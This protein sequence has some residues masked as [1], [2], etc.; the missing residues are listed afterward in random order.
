MGGRDSSMTAEKKFLNPPSLQIIETLSAFAEESATDTADHD[1]GTAIIQEA[2]AQLHEADIADLIESLSKHHRQIVWS[3]L[4]KA[5]LG[6]VLLEVGN[7]LC[8]DL[9]ELTPTDT[10]VSLLKN[11]DTSDA[12]GL[13]RELPKSDAAKFIRLANLINNQE[14]RAS[15]SFKEDTVG[16]LMDFQPVIANELDTVGDILVSLRQMKSLPSHCDKLF[17]VDDWERLAG[18]LPLNRL[19]LNEPE[20]RVKDIMKA[21]NLHTFTAD[22]DLN[23]ASGAFERYNLISA[24]VIDE[25]HKIIGRITI[26]EIF[27]YFHEAQNTDLLTSAGISDKED[28]FATLGERFSNRW[29]WLFVN[30]IA[31][32]LI[33][34]IIGFF[35]SSIQHVVALAALMPVVAGMSGNMGNQTATLIIRALAMQQVKASNWR[36]IMQGEIKLSLLNGLL[37]GGLVGGVAYVLYARPD[38]SVV[39]VMAMVI[40]SFLGALTGFFVPIIMQRLGRD[41]ALGA[42]VVIS[43]VTDSL[44]FLFFLGMGTIFLI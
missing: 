34:R 21:N 17:I 37:W 40:C 29:R 24:P 6:E 22:V 16:V 41:P 15:L 13:L 36:A 38:L 39:V 19:V 11:M 10:I 5:V 30:L 33:S 43:V 42:T 18:V 32:I 27:D 44:G 7:N 31:A 8:R 4:D 14:I 3:L 9:I 25:E 26:D 35:E 2:L 1:E 28:L 12:A 20:V 23:T